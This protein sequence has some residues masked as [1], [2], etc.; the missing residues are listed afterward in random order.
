MGWIKKIGIFIMDYVE[1]YIGSNIITNLSPNYIDIYGQLNYKNVEIYNKMIGN[2]FEFNNPVIKNNKQFLYI[3]LP[4]WFL[5]NYGLSIPLVALQYNKIQFKFK[6]KELI[7]TIF[8][9]ISDI[10]STTN[11]NLRNNIIDLIV[12]STINILQEQI[13]ITLLAEF[14]FLDNIERKKFAQSSHEY[15]ITQVQ[16][17]S[18]T[19]VSPY[20][21]NFELD[22][23]HCCKTMFW[24]ANQYKYINNLVGENQYDKYT[25]S[26]YQPS[27]SNT[28]TNYINFLKMMHSSAVSFNLNTFIEGLNSLLNSPINDTL[29]VQDIVIAVTE[30]QN[31]KKYEVSPFY[32]TQ[33]TLNSTSLVSQNYPYFNFLQ[34]YNYYKN[35][36][37]LGINLYSFSLG[38][39]ET[40]PLGSC[41]LSRIPKTSIKFNLINPDINLTNVNTDNNYSIIDNMSSI[42]LNNYKINVQVENYNVLRFIGGIVGIAFTY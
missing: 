1:M 14:V 35:T 23:F 11:N 13:E 3:P 33:I 10:S 38:P 17:L 19:N 5:N 39:T 20:N 29:Y 40:Q 18:F 16:Q 15:L 31:Y 7:E 4:F 41:N 37:G 12:S 34:P 30:T 9:N 28:N 21:S 36:P 8:F 26:L 6:F 32:A 42:N 2:T 22:F 25:V 27:Y 24:S